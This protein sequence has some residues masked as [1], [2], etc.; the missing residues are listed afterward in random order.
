MG[1]SDILTSAARGPILIHGRAGKPF[2]REITAMAM[3]RLDWTVSLEGFDDLLSDVAAMLGGRTEPEIYPSILSTIV[4][5]VD[6]SIADI[7]GS[8]V[9]A[10]RRRLEVDVFARR[11]GWALRTLESRLRQAQAA[12]PKSILGMSLVLQA[13]WRLDVLGLAPKQVAHLAGFGGVSA[14]SAGSSQVLEE[15]SPETLA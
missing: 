12:P 10:G 7:V 3:T 6:Q 15:L 11:C 2:I 4:R 13:T 1:W 14:S 9:I 8:A 5:S